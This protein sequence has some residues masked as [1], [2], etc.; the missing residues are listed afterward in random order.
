[1][2]SVTGT[3]KM[4]HMKKLLSLL[5]TTAL[6]AGCK[7]NEVPLYDGPSSVF[8]DVF[9]EYVPGINYLNDS[10]IISFAFTPQ[11]SDSLV[12]LR[13]RTQGDTAGS[14]RQIS[15]RVVDTAAFAA[16]PEQYEL[17]AKLEVPAGKHFVMLPI[18]LKKTPEMQQ[19]NYT[20]T[21]ELQE[22]GQFHVP[23]ST[24]FVPET[25]RHVSVKYHTVVITDILTRPRYWFDPYLGTF[26]RKKLL[27]L[28]ELLDLPVNILE[29]STTSIGTTRF[30]GRYMRNYLEAEAAADRTVLDEDGSVMK[31]GDSL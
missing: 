2:K 30:Y 31:M 9:R 24:S 18:I 16:K 22:N 17:P 23:V 7:K 13:I 20:L 21:L 26:S 29:L 19:Q 25:G 15:Y 3:K 10:T 14:P 27:L 5:I 6:I 11:T 28:C 4:Q 8:F 12:Y 1:M